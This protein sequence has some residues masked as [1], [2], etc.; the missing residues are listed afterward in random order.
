MN[1]NV[2]WWQQ[3]FAVFWPFHDADA[4]GVEVI[5]KAGIKELV[6]TFH[7]VQVKVEQFDSLSADPDGVG[8]AQRIGRTFDMP[9][10]TG[11]VQHGACER[12]FAGAE[13]AAQVDRKPGSER[14]SERCAQRERAG[15]FVEEKF[16]MRHRIE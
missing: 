1:R 3:G 4:V 15:F 2:G 5:A 11:G 6:S 8:L 7:A 14:A 9:G 16:Q 10:M 12:G 13:L